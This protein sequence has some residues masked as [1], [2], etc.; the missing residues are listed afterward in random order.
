LRFSF[1][2]FQF[3]LQFDSLHSNRSKKAKRSALFMKTLLKLCMM[4]FLLVGFGV[5]YA[6]PTE[7][8][9]ANTYT[10]AKGDTLS[11][12]AKKFPGT[13]WQ[14]L[15]RTNNIIDVNLIYPN[16]ILT[17]TRT[18]SGAKE[19]TKQ[20]HRVKTTL[21]TASR[22]AYG[23]IKRLEV[24]CNTES[25]LE[26]LKY[27]HTVHTALKAKMLKQ[28]EQATSLGERSY[29]VNEGA[30]EYVFQ[31]TE[32]CLYAKIVRM[33]ELPVAPR[34][35]QSD[36]TATGV[37]SESSPALPPEQTPRYAQDEEFRSIKHALEEVLPD[38][39]VTRLA[40]AVLRQRQHRREI[41]RSD[42]DQNL[43]SKRNDQAVNLP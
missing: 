28:N 32:N 9:N 15:A 12:I 43:V 7:T 2:V 36:R 34:D 27:P 10:V 22:A 33:N 25:G 5:A 41:S 39:D 1:P 8:T 18:N 13:T 40:V 42:L 16:T 29:S 38:Q 30:H 20:T 4:L 35:T 3:L 21:S 6:A 14:T 24:S 17:I 19:I 23:K 11:A 31:V 26:Q 37:S